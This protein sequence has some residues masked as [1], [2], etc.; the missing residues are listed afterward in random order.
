MNFSMKTRSSPNEDLRFGAGEREALGDLTLAPRDTHALAAAARRCLDHH[1]ES[2]LERSRHGGF[3]RVDDAEMPGI[4]ETPAKAASFFEFDLVAHR[5]DRNGV[6]PDEGDP[7]GCE[8]LGKGSPLGEEPVARMDRLGP[9]LQ[10]GVDDPV[11]DEIRGRGRRRPDRDRLV[12][13][14]HMEGVTVDIAIDGDGCDPHPARGFDDANGDL[15]A[16]G[17]QDFPEHRQELLPR[18]D[19]LCTAERGERQLGLP[20]G[21]IRDRGRRRSR[22]SS[23]WRGCCRI[24]RSPPRRRRRCRRCRTRA[25]ACRSRR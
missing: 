6:R 4:V 8:R 12:G 21:A 7:G 3:R 10:A 20:N 23:M 15:A 9:A 16:I 2:D 5:R 18:F 13:H 19:R 22:C 25:G 24:G 14:L 1:R 17:D 11:D